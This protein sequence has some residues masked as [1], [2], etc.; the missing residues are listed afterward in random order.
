MVY[1]AAKSQQSNTYQYP[2]EKKCEN[3]LKYLR[4]SVKIPNGESSSILSTNH[5]SRLAK[6]RT[7]KYQKL[8]QRTLQQCNNIYIKPDRFKENLHSLILKAQLK[9]LTPDIPI[10]LYST[11]SGHHLQSGYNSCWGFF[12]LI[13]RPT[14]V[15]CDRFYFLSLSLERVSYKAVPRTDTNT[16]NWRLYVLLEDS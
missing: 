5:F 16:E 14:D 2:T 15:T 3:F 4:T 9:L 6:D 1:S 12:S 7:E 11:I 13:S 8:I 10:R